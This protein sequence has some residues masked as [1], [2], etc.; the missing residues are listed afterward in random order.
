MASKVWKLNG[1]RGIAYVEGKETAE[2]V[3]AL[4]GNMV[5]RKLPEAAMAEYRDKK[6]R[7][8]AWQ[9]PFDLSR[10]D[11]ISEALGTREHSSL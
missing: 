8:F 4:C 7:A 3:M 5:E 10:W 11:I 9:I 6:G 2:R 1:R